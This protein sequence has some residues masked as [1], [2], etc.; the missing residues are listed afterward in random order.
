MPAAA[1]QGQPLAPRGLPSFCWQPGPGAVLH[2]HCHRAAGLLQRRS[3]QW[4]RPTVCLWNEEGGQSVFSMLGMVTQES[5]CSFE[6]KRLEETAR[7]VF[8]EKIGEGDKTAVKQGG[9]DLP[10]RVSDRQPQRK[11]H[12]AISE[13]QQHAPHKYTTPGSHSL[14]LRH[15]PRRK[16]HLCHALTAERQPTLAS[17]QPSRLP[18]PPPAGWVRWVLSSCSSDRPG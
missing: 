15:P 5:Q 9:F 17:P 14:P 7:K 2:R 10:V 4:G 13:F 6:T 1:Q 8:V 12:V 3:P 16:A 18:A 11:M